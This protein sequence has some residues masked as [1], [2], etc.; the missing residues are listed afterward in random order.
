M[1]G[2]SVQ[3]FR[4]MRRCPI[5]SEVVVNKR[6]HIDMHYGIEYDKQC[7]YC[8]KI[9]AHPGN[10]RIH[11][12]VHSEAVQDKSVVTAFTSE[13]EWPHQC[14][15]CSKRFRF[16]SRLLEH[17]TIHSKERPYTCLYCPKKFKQ[18]YSVWE[19]LENTHATH[20]STQVNK[21]NPPKSEI[22]SS[23]KTKTTQTMKVKGYPRKIR[24]TLPDSIQN[25]NLCPRVV[26]SRSLTEVLNKM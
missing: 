8:D 21:M 9:F 1:M 11:E 23:L 4:S 25:A 14:K 24:Y 2:D 18:A 13:E 5:C 12:R 20:N 6:Q 16:S 17:T 19:H 22:K 3:N 15:F 10:L 26:L 7:R